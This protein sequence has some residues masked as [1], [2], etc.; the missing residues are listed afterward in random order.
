MAFGVGSIVL[1]SL[2]SAD[3][4]ENATEG[5][6]V[7]PQPPCYGVV[8]ADA[9]SAASWDIL[10]DNGNFTAGVATAAVDD[11]Y[12]VSNAERTRLWGKI[13]SIAG[14]AENYTGQVVTMYRRGGAANPEKALVCGLTTGVYREVLTSALAAVAGR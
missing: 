13:V 2:A 1:I 7:N 14:E 4:P 12:A 9:G 11:L 6:D 8:V 5:P 3:L 10:W